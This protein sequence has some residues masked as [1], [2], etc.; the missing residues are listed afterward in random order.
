[1]LIDVAIIATIEADSVD[2]AYK[3]AIHLCQSISEEFFAEGEQ[4]FAVTNYDLGYG[5]RRI[6]SLHPENYTSDNTSDS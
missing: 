4:I 3:D 5:G 2:A 1:M 6:V